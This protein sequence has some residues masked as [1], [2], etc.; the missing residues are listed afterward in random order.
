MPLCLLNKVEGGVKVYTHILSLSHAMVDNKRAS[1]RREQWGFDESAFEAS[2]PRVFS[3]FYTT[4]A[5][6]LRSYLCMSILNLLIRVLFPFPQ[7]L[8]NGQCSPTARVSPP[9]SP[10]WL[11]L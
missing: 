10:V 3:N 6:I 7:C 1:S 4:I 9:T 2:L 11:V 8:L 5:R